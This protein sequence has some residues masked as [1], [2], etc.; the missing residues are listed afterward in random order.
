MFF[1]DLQLR[2]FDIYILVYNIYTFFFVKLE[3]NKKR[4][5][6]FLETDYRLQN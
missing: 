5:L 3:K 1:S 4:F 6:K 2:L